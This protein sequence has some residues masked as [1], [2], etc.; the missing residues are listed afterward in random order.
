[1]RT[2]L[3]WLLL[4]LT[5][6]AMSA[7]TFSTP[8]GGRDAGGD[9][10]HDS[11]PHD[12][13]RPDANASCHHDCFGFSQCGDGGVVTTWAH[14]PIPCDRW[15]GVCPSW[16]SYQCLRGCR[17]D[18][19]TIGPFGEPSDACEENRPKHAGDRC[20]R[21]SDCEPQRAAYGYACDSVVNVYLRCDFASG[22]CVDRE[23][24]I[25]EDW[26]AP[27]GLTRDGGSGGYAAGAIPSSACRGGWCVY[28]EED[29]CVLQGCTIACKADSDCPMGA[30]C[31][32]AVC[33][34]GPPNLTGCGLSCP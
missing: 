5:G 17:I 33:K 8:D 29:W 14:A 20:G 31:Q 18:N 23:R 26:L 32:W 11:G 19:Q 15:E 28:V 21:E 34:P 1:M 25:V 22:T 9:A 30:V 4:A 24:P 13:G 7:D 3:P 12:A 16:V 10:A 6:C 2:P 27:C